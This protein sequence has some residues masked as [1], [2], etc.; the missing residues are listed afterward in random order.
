MGG[1]NLSYLANDKINVQLIGSKVEKV[2]FS[3]T[4]KTGLSLVSTDFFEPRDTAQKNLYL[5]HSD[6]GV[7]E[8][9]FSFRNTLNA[10]L[11]VIIRATFDWEDGG[12]FRNAATIWTGTIPTDSRFF[13]TSDKNPTVVETTTQKIIDI[14]ELRLPY[15]VFLIQINADV[16][17]TS[18]EVR[19]QTVR[20]Y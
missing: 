15:P 18:G 9:G 8:Q 2:T 7:F 16:A 3:K 14:A 6:I 1:F 17:P 5:P 20:R 10:N 12:G 13:F 4:N 19:I 11:T